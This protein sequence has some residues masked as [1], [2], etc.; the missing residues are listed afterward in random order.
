MSAGPTVAQIRTGLNAAGEPT[1]L[2]PLHVQALKAWVLDEYEG[3]SGIVEKA[4]ADFGSGAGRT[5]RQ[6]AALGYAEA[7][8][9]LPAQFKAVLSEGVAWLGQRA[10]FRA[11]QPKTLEA[12][13]VAALGIAL[14][15][16]KIRGGARR[17][18]AP[19]SCGSERQVPRH[20]SY[21]AVA[22]YRDCACLGSPATA[23]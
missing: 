8:G 10:W 19:K 16:Q 23:G 15:M 11:F 3:L 9:Q 20:F 21:R 18:L 12:D 2:T 14:G 6:V 17:R 13:G 7:G 1:L 5:A 4:A 22:F